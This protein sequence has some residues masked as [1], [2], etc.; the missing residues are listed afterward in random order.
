[1]PTESALAGLEGGQV[2][3]LNANYEPLNVTSMRRAVVLLLMDKAAAIRLDSL[4]FHS[5]FEAVRAPTVVKLHSYVHRPVP[6]LSLSRK[7]IMARDNYQCQYCGRKDRALTLDHVI[8]RT[9]GGQTTWDNLVA[10]CQ[11]CNGRKGQHRL[12]EVNMKLLRQPVRPRFVPYISLSKFVAA[13]HKPEWREYLLPF[14]KGL[15]FLEDD[16]SHD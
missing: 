10:C 12:E 4:T 8:P 9:R 2:L 3:V 5:E 11:R 1:M 16:L 14:S 13:L 15:D 7:A 6:Q